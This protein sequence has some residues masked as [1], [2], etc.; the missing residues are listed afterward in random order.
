M[1]AEHLLRVLQLGDSLFPIGSFSWSDG[2]ETATASGRIADAAGLE[3][4]TRQ[5]LDGMFTPCEGLAAKRAHQY[6]VAGEWQRLRELDEE[7]TA[8]RPAASTR[9]SSVSIGRRLLATAAAVHADA[10]LA[11]LHALVARD[12][13]SG[14]VAV[15]HGALFAALGVGERHAVAGFA[16]TRLAGIVSAALRLMPIGQVQ[17]QVVLGRML[18]RVPA[19]V[20][21]VIAAGDAPLRAFAP[22]VDVQQMNH[23][24][25]YSRLFRS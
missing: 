22:L 15:V 24:D 23:R 19:A 6:S 16:Y 3:A 21:A 1:D 10:A 4:W 20:D 17:G 8:L 11:P 9:A 7:L 13:R 5:Y 25:V 18:A 2:L 12:D 14:N